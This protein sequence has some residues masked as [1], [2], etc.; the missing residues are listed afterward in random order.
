MAS[1]GCFFYCWQLKSASHETPT[2]NCS[3][4][5]HGTMVMGKKKKKKKTLDTS[6]HLVPQERVIKVV[7]KLAVS[8]YGRNITEGVWWQRGPAGPWLHGY[9]VFI[10]IHIGL[11]GQHCLG[12]QQVSLKT[13]PQK[14]QQEPTVW[15]HIQTFFSYKTATVGG[16][17]MRR[18]W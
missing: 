15:Q 4:L 16:L 9:C 2:N 8:E 12:W 11:R 18:H 6:F 1:I 17:E 13:N 3:Y 14:Q 10:I 7:S 5:C